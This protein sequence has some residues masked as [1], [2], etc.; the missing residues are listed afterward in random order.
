MDDWQQDWMKA[1][2]TVSTG[3]EQFLETVNKEVGEVVD[4]L[5]DFTDDM[6]DGLEQTIAP[7]LEQF[8]EQV[9]EWMEPFLL[10]LTGFESSV[11]QA[12]EPFTHTVEPFLNQHPV[13]V[14]CR[15]YH[16]QT[17]NGVTLICAMHPYGIV[18]GSDSCP[19]KEA[20]SWSLPSLSASDPS[21]D[22]D[23]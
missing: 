11:D 14:G 22:R 1:L 5:A 19:D 2:E 4:A 23:Y 20:V 8:D 17:Y 13:C 21:D 7:G 10:A 12:V 18:D 6:V 15:H 3:I 16:G 9:A